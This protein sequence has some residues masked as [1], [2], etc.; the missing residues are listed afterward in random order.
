MTLLGEIVTWDMQST[1]VKYSDVLEALDNAGLS[2]DYAGEMR[3]T[4]AFSRA[5]KHLKANRTIDRLKRKGDQQQYQLTAKQEVNDRI[6]YHYETVLDLDVETGSVYCEDNEDLADEA[7]KLTAYAMQTRTSQDITRIVQRLFAE[8]SSLFPINPRKGVAYFVPDEH[9]EF[10]AK[11]QQFLVELGG[12]L[13]RFPVPAGTEGGN[14]SVAEAVSKGLQSLVD[15]LEDAVDDWNQETRPGTFKRAEERLDV[16][17]FK[18]EAYAQHL[19]EKQRE[20]LDKL[21]EA[22]GRVTS[23]ASEILSF[24]NE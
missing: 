11:V 16:I 3:Y 1:E 14:E 23:K 18:V 15:E 12:R 2:R 10:T 20:L 8:N 21:A 5:S 13:E 4:N 17:Q 19:G 9:R 22:R 6:D 7:T 24:D